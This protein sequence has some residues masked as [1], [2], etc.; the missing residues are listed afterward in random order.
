[1][2]R[3]RTLRD[4][5]Q[6]LELSTATVSRAL[7]GD[8]AIAL[9]TRQRVTAAA[10]DAGYVPNVAGRMLARGRSGF[11]SMVLPVR[12]PSLVDSFLGEFV[13]GLSEGLVE[14]GNDLILA[15]AA[16][17]QSELAVLKHL[18]ASGRADGV[19]V[20]RIAEADERVSYLR[21]SQVPFVAHGRL[22]DEDLSYPWLDTDG[23]LAFGRAFDMLYELGHRHFGLLTITEPMT[24]RHLR[25]EGLI[26]AI[27]ERGDPLVSLDVAEAP[28]F[29]RSARLEAI[30]RLLGAARR[31][32][33]VLA[34][35]DELALTVMEVAMR[36]GLSIPQDLSVIGFDNVP[37]AAYAPPGLT[38]FDA[39]IRKA[40]RDIGGLL[41]D[42]IEN[43]DAPPAR[44]LMRPRL[45]PRG[46]HGAA[47]DQSGGRMTTNKVSQGG[48]TC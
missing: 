35:F 45:V 32:T 43:P 48:Q 15:T 47:P 13:T 3:A 27:A 28:R 2:R 23:A 6:G 5:A 41:V 39:E 12:G 24:F 18:V 9:V 4:L 8:E 11:V 17:G 37:A 38:T 21:E 25:Q 1:M 40:A 19:V 10:R 42:S 44:R 29:D 36:E 20:T 16:E 26:A 14:R 34:L 22:I 31:P 30:S 33:A 46:S 7:A